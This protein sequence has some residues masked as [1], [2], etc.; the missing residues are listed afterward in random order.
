MELIKP[1]YVVIGASAA[2]LGA[3]TKL[4]EL[5]PTATIVC[6]TAE[7]DIP[8]NRCLLSDL[9]AGSKTVETIAAKPDRFFM[10]KNIFLMRNAPVID[11]N[12]KR[13]TVRLKTGQT[14]AYDKLF[15]GT[16][17]SGWIPA[18]PGA[19]SSGVF[20]FYSTKN[21]RDI[22]TYIA[23]HIIRHVT[24]VGA[25]LSGLECADALA[26][27][28]LPVTIIEQASHILPHQLNAE[29]AALL[30]SLLQQKGVTIRTAC[31]VDEIGDEKNL[32]RSVTLSDGQTLETD[33]V[34]FALGG[35]INIELAQIAGLTCYGNGIITTPTMQTSNPHIFA[36]GD[37]CVVKDLLT[38]NLVQSCTWPDA[39][40]QGMTAAFNMTGGQRQYE[41]VVIITSSTIANTTFVTCGPIANPSASYQQIVTQG[42]GFYHLR[43]EEHGVL[44][45]F[46]MVGNVDNVG[47][48]RREMMEGR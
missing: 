29:G 48:L 14:I 28:G 33:M 3:V 41:G 23:D 1:T 32:V 40:L 24:V 42:D 16:G 4:R 11:I 39:V 10:E 8:C 22:L 15:L 45:G 30:A 17:R 2:G 19:Q 34:I 18:I 38:G 46:A 26:T 37:V 21:A 12:P 6:L 20:P 7:S 44:K 43:L 25:G 5:D 31:R 9:V 36:G 35:K 13:Q 47:Q 27:R